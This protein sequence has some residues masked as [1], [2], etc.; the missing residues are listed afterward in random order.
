MALNSF[1]LMASAFAILVYVAFPILV[2]ATPAR[3]EV[4]IA[5]MNTDTLNSKRGA[6]EEDVQNQLRK[7]VDS[8]E[9]S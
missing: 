5:N 4:A 9:S 7:R 3:I 6:S 1:S 8:Y 2:Y